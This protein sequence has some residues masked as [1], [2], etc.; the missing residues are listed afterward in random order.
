MGSMA[1]LMVLRKCSNSAREKPWKT[2]LLCLNNHMDSDNDLDLNRPE[3][4]IFSPI[5]LTSPES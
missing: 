4:R 5:A 3:L 2:H 1:D